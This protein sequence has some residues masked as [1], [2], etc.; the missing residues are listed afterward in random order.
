MSFCQK[1]GQ[2]TCSVRVDYRD[3]C[4]EETLQKFM[5][6]CEQAAGEGECG[7]AFW[8]KAPQLAVDEAL[9]HLNHKLAE[10]GLISYPGKLTCPLGSLHRL[11]FGVL[12]FCLEDSSG[13]DDVGARQRSHA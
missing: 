3:H 8:V 12:H 10:L 7:I 13:S 9:E 1:L 6:Q 11:D 5:A 4:V 2:N